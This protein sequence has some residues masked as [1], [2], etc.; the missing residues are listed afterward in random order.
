MLHAWSRWIL[1][2]VQS[3]SPYK[4]GTFYF[5]LTIPSEFPFKA[6]T[7][8]HFRGAMSRSAVGDPSQVTFTTK[9]YHPGINEEGSICVPILRDQVRCLPRV[10]VS[11][12]LDGREP[13]QWKPSITLSTGEKYGT[14]HVHCGCLCVCCARSTFGH[15]GEGE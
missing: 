12:Q 7:V 14:V 3:D 5:K 13:V 11:A 10:S 15:S 9:I 8:W 1:N 6:P 4:G 2:P